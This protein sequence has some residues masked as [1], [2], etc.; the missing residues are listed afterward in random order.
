MKGL[1]NVTLSH[2]K[3]LQQAGLI[4]HFMKVVT[5]HFLASQWEDPT[6]I[7]FH[8]TNKSI[9]RKSPVELGKTLLSFK[10]TTNAIPIEAGDQTIDETNQQCSH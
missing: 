5:P 10:E 4:Q 7:S 2:G 9:I 8:K 3:G 6:F 1:I